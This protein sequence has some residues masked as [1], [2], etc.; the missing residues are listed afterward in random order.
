MEDR[1]SP[2]VTLREIQR[3]TFL[4][5]TRLKTADAEQTET[6]LQEY[7]ALVDRFYQ[8]SVHLAPHQYEAAKEDAEYFLRLL[9]LAI[10]YEATG[11]QNEPSPP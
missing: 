1:E 5:L 3:S 4:I 8:V 9:D 11:D 7:L 10:Q 2:I 6:A